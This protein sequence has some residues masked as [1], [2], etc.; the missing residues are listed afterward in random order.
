VGEG[1]REWS[2]VQEFDWSEIKTN[3]GEAEAG[4][5]QSD[6]YALFVTAL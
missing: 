3:L 2:G 6:G 1:D 5:G 4:Q